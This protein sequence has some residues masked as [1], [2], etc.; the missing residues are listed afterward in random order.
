MENSVG[1]ARDALERAL[2]ND[3]WP[4]VAAVGGWWPRSNTPEVDLVGADR[5]PA[6]RLGFVGT[7]K[8]RESPLERRDVD[9]LARDAIAVPGYTAGVPLVS[10]CPAGGGTHGSPT[11]GTP[12]TC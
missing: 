12:T 5:S 9:V 7:I 11:C 3:D 8:W 1:R 10:V 4:D 2:P 6:T